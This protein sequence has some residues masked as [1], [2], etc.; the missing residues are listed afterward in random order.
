MRAASLA[1]IAVHRLELH[2]MLLVDTVE[3]NLSIDVSASILWGASGKE[4]INSGWKL[5]PPK[6]IS[7]VFESVIRSS[8]T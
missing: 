2:R 4:I 8:L 1:F 7:D 5:D 6:A 3:L